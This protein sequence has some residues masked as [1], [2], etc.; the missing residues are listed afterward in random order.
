MSVGIYETYVSVQVDDHSFEIIGGLDQ[1]WGFVVEKPIV[2]PETKMSKIVGIKI[3]DVKKVAVFGEDGTILFYE[4]VNNSRV[5]PIYE[6]RCILEPFEKV[7]TFDILVTGQIVALT[8]RFKDKPSASRL[9]VYKVDP[10]NPTNK[11]WIYDFSSQPQKY[12]PSDFYSNFFN[13][14][15]NY[16]FDGAPVIIGFQGSN[17]GQSTNLFVAVLEKEGIRELLYQ[18]EYLKGEFI[19]CTHYQGCIYSLDSLMTLKYAH[20]PVKQ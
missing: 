5:K 4:I 14:K 1:K 9:L 13:I 10:K 20:L 8:T 18:V 16:L 12:T 6:K 15:I 3:Y 11:H 7:D 17:E 2:I 19:D